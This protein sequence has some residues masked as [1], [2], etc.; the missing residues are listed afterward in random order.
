[1]FDCEYRYTM[2]RQLKLGDTIVL[3]AC[4]DSISITFCA[5]DTNTGYNRR[6]NVINKADNT[7]D[8]L[9][10]DKRF[11]YGGTNGLRLKIEDDLP[12]KIALRIWYN[13]LY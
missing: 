13:Y 6:F 1:M 9:W 4:P 2:L 3:P 7:I 11:K 8:D 12:N 10:I 5:S